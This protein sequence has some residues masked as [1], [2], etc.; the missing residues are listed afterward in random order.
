MVFKVLSAA[1][2]ILVHESVAER[3][4]SRG[5]M[6]E[7]AVIGGIFAGPPRIDDQV[8]VCFPEAIEPS[9]MYVTNRELSCLRL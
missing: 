6:T 2:T 8:S 7:L 5:A 9:V 3:S 4:A 1:S